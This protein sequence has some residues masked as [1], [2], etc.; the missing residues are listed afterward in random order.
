MQVNYTV[1]VCSVAPE[2]IAV[3]DAVR[4]WVA[5]REA[6]AMALTGLARK[7]LTRAGMPDVSVRK[8]T[9]GFAAPETAG[10]V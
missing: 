1:R 2:E 10:L 4:R 5:L 9:P 6:A 8:N 3:S 7:V